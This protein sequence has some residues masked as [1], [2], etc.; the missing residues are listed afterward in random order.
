MLL[1]VV[2]ALFKIAYKKLQRVA[3][4]SIWVISNRLIERALVIC[5]FDLVTQLSE[6]RISCLGREI[7]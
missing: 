4:D 3:R 5:R 1:F 6:R 7:K 2:I